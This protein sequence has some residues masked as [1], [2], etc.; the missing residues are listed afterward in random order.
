ML[1]K[2]GVTR[3]TGLSHVVPLG[4]G[5]V[6]AFQSPITSYHILEKTDYFKREGRLEGEVGSPAL[7]KFI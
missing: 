2:N 1:W 6:P 5:F 3:V 4:R 7:E